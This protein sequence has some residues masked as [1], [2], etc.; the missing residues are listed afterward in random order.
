M[1]C[2]FIPYNNNFKIPFRSWKACIVSDPEILS[3]IGHLC[4]GNSAQDSAMLWIF[5]KNLHV[6]ICI[7]ALAIWEQESCNGISVERDE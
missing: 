3:A 5:S 7:K 2:F 6:S 1:L 4:M